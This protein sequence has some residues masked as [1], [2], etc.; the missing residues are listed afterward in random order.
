MPYY[1]DG[2]SAA[3]GNITSTA[4]MVELGNLA[5]EQEQYFLE[6]PGWIACLYITRSLGILQLGIHWK[7]SRNVYALFIY[8]QYLP[9]LVLT[10]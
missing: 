9:P 8:L 4:L 5:L 3:M 7:G 2:V 10:V 1:I 6:C